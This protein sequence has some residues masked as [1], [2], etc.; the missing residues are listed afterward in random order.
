MKLY[1]HDSFR[2]S[3]IARLGLVFV[4]YQCRACPLRDQR[5]RC[6]ATAAGHGRDTR[7]ALTVRAQIGPGEARAR[8]SP[9]KWRALVIQL[10][11][12]PAT[13]VC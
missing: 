5:A 8:A 1:W 9:A 7:R 12:V 10:P 13:A 4:W 3:H 6:T 2:V 11:K